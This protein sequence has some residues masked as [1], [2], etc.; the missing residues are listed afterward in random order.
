MVGARA[1]GR[2]GRAGGRG[3]AGKGERGAAWAGTKKWLLRGRA[4][5]WVCG[6]GAGV[7]GALQSTAQGRKGEVWAMGLAQQAFYC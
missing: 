7:G 1:G 5:T 4:D 6:V 2:D 3:R